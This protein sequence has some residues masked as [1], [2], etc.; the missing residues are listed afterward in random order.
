MRKQK[1]RR[2]RKTGAARSAY[3]RLFSEGMFQGQAGELEGAAAR[4]EWDII[5]L[6]LCAA[7]AEAR[8]ART[9]PPVQLCSRMLAIS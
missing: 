6:S 2:P 9:F 7:R 8:G 1:A 3:G 5:S 4:L